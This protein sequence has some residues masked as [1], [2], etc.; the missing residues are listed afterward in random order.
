MGERVCTGRVEVG[1][2]SVRVYEL[3]VGEVRAWLADPA[4][5]GQDIVA[6]G[7]FEDVS[8]ADLVRMTDLEPGEL[9][10]LLPSQLRQVA[11]ACREA[12]PH[13]FA[14]VGRIAASV[15]PAPTAPEP[16]LDPGRAG[17][18]AH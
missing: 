7:L 14:L 12:N 4:A 6:L 3:T 9:D 1:G 11:D 13:F 10:G 8:L 5:Q 18:A 17:T 2:R 15:R 16:G